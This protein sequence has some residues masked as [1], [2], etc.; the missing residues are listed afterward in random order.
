M[1]L[2]SAP[3]GYGKTTLV[4]DWL[5]TS[6]A[7]VVWLSLSKEDNELAIFQSLF[8]AAIH[9]VNPAIANFMSSNPTW[10]QPEEEWQ[11]LVS[12]IHEMDRVSP[13]VIIVLDDYHVINNPHIHEFVQ[14]YL[15][16][17]SCWMDEGSARTHG[18]HPILIT[19]ND[20]PFPIS[21]WRTHEETIE[22][23]AEDLKF[24]K[25]ETTEF[26]QQKTG[27]R[28]PLPCIDRIA[29]TTEGWVT[30]LQLSVLTIHSVRNRQGHED[31]RDINGNDQ[32][33]IDYMMEQVIKQLPEE[34]QKFLF[35]TSIL[36]NISGDLCDCIR[37]EKGSQRIIEQLIHDNLFIIPMDNQRGWYRYHQ[38]F[39]DVLIHNQYALG[40][41]LIAESHCRAA[42]WLAEKGYYPESL[43][44]WLTA[45]NIQEA[46]RVMEKAGPILLN[47]AQ[48]NLLD[49]LLISFPAS[50][51]DRYP[52]LCIYR[53]WS[54]SDAY[55]EKLDYWLDKSI[56]VIHDENYIGKYSEAEVNIMMG[57]VY[58]I[59]ALQKSRFGENEACMDYSK[60]ALNLLPDA[61]LNVIG[62]SLLAMAKIHLL[63]GDMDEALRVFTQSNAMQQEGG[64]ISGVIEALY[65]CGE[66][67]SIQGKLKGAYQYFQESAAFIDQQ[68]GKGYFISPVYSGLGLIEMEWNQLVKAERSFL[69]SQEVSPPR[70]SAEYL[71]SFSAR[72]EYDLFMKNMVDADL[73]VEQIEPFIVHPF[74][75]ESAK[76]ILIKN[77]LMYYLAAGNFQVAQR[78]IAERKIESIHLE[79]NL[80][81]PEVIGLFDYYWK[82]RDDVRLIQSA[83]KMI[84]VLQKGNRL[85]QLI[86]VQLVYSVCLFRT[87]FQNEAVNVFLEAIQNGIWEGYF[88]TYVEIGPPLAELIHYVVDS[89]RMPGHGD[90]PPG[91]LRRIDSAIHEREKTSQRTFAPVES[92]SGQ[93]HEQVISTVE[94]LTATELVVLRYLARGNDNKM[95]ARELRLSTN[96]IK[97]HLSNI[98]SKLGA[99]NRVDAV[100]KGKELKLV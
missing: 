22:V 82:T 4:S 85:D 36:E 71:I 40:A 18:F 39:L 97:T 59:R 52:W 81:M 93:P 74:V 78:I 54:S 1:T 99:H 49:Q 77:L 83:K 28:I 56:R 17:Y 75:P 90:A 100:N 29:E 94:H 47:T 92:G 88:N 64:N 21:N 61:E 57:N 16:N 24:S 42:R 38:L 15:Q 14:F 63:N 6:K 58:T 19:R 43:Q 60:K 41:D 33:V 7:P 25:E 45:G 73:V 55:E 89:K 48:F 67:L 31:T 91:F 13:G 84:P 62:L 5:A 11:Q 95:I 50:A 34:T 35:Q 23:R 70:G 76:S 96:T 69:K 27:G 66:I 32:M 79:N 44:H 2:I 98:Y 51:F 26:L 72:L 65:T 10:K 20:P 12:I 30:G 86:H 80:R 68:I 9:Q 37:G 3:A 8:T 87:G 53:A 46:A